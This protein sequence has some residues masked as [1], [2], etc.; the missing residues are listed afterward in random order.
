MSRLGEGQAEA[1]RQTHFALLREAIRQAS[2]TEV[3]NLGDGL[4][5]VFNSAS[6]A[7][8]CAVAMQQALDRHNRRGGEPLLMRV[9]I[10]LGEVTAEDGDYFGTP[11][12]EASRLCDHAVGRQ[13]LLTEMAKTLAGSRGRPTLRVPWRSGTQRPARLRGRRGGHVATRR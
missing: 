12:V 8:G 4:M 2:G 7:V 3:K 1:L 11:V 13:I 5:V 6:D 10:A 9:G